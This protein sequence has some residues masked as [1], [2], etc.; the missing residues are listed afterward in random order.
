MDLAK[1]KSRMAEKRSCVCVFL[2][3]VA[4]WF[5]CFSLFCLVLCFCYGIVTA[6]QDCIAGLPAQRFGFTDAP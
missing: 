6:I 5:L 4:C 3:V 1:A 2:C